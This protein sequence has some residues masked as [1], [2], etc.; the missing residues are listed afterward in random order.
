MFNLLVS[1]SIKKNKTAAYRAVI[2]VILAVLGTGWGHGECSTHNNSIKGM[3]IEDVR[4]VNDSI[5]LQTTG[6]IFKVNE[7]AGTME[8]YQRIGKIS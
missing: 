1:N 2:I 5:H 3:R 7:N 4:V 8:I 6:A